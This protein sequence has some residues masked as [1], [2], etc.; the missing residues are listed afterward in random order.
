M[1]TLIAILS[2]MAFGLVAGAI[3]RFLVP[4]RQAIGLLG[5]IVLGIVGSLVGGGLTWLFTR[6]PMEPAG[7]IMS[8]LG[9][10]VV[11]AIAMRFGRR[12]YT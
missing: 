7:W 5:T 10:V 4:G 12:Q 6:D 3:A 1:E 9:A 8:I 2:W 11:L